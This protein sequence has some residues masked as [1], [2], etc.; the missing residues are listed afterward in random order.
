[1]ASGHQGG[2][3]LELEQDNDE[4]QRQEDLE[5]GRTGRQEAAAEKEADEKAVEVAATEETS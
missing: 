4:V 1:M 2:L 3:A 5:K